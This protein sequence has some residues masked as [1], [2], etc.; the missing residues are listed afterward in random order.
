MTEPTAKI[1]D[2]GDAG[3]I[4]V[5]KSGWCPI[6][7]AGTETRTLAAPTF[8]GQELWLFIKTD[9]GTCVI[10]AAAAINAAGNTI[11]TMADVTDTMFLKAVASGSTLVWRVVSSDGSALS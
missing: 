3:A 1:A 6:V 2:P 7:T 4:P 11:M 5:T 8:E 9:G 10:T